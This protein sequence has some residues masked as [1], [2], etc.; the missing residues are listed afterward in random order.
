MPCPEE[1]CL[2][3]FQA[4]GTQAPGSRLKN[5]LARTSPRSRQPWFPTW[6]SKPAV[7][8]FTVKLCLLC[9]GR[10]SHLE[11]SSA[12]RHENPSWTIPEPCQKI[13]LA[14]HNEIKRACVPGSQTILSLRQ[15]SGR[16]PSRVALRE[17][18]EHGALSGTGGNSMSLLLSVNRCLY[19]GGHAFCLRMKQS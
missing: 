14:N 9:C 17:R 5:N 13:T 3:A 18:A 15:L 8:A 2:L 19:L 6:C 1:Q 4:L 10:G 12:F 16:K 11:L 7:L